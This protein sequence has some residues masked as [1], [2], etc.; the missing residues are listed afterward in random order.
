[1][2]TKTFWDLGKKE[3]KTNFTELL[4]ILVI[5]T[6]THLNMSLGVICAAVKGK[7]SCMQ[8]NHLG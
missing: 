7:G 8:P 6:M 4:K 5:L 1:M 3:N 2:G